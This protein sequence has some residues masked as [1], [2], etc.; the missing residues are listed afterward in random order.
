MLAWTSMSYR[1]S[2]TISLQ[3]WRQ[4]DAPNEA[5]AGGQRWGQRV[6]GRLAPRHGSRVVEE[7]PFRSQRREVPR[8]AIQ[9]AGHDFARRGKSSEH[10]EGGG[11]RRRDGWGSERRAGRSDP[12]VGAASQPRPRPRRGSLLPAL[13]VV[14]ASP[15]EGIASESHVSSGANRAPGCSRIRRDEDRHAGDQNRARSRK[16]VDRHIMHLC[17]LSMANWKRFPNRRD[18]THDRQAGAAELGRPPGTG[19]AVKRRYYSNWMRLEPRLRS[20][21]AVFVS[22][23]DDNPAV[24]RVFCPPNSACTDPQKSDQKRGTSLSPL[25]EGG[26]KGTPTELPDQPESGGGTGARRPAET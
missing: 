26:W 13:R 4:S 15:R 5:I 25:N 3:L 24:A 14:A 2:T 7:A 20:C 19:G 23:F 21:I 17:R 9:F 1:I 8:R 16:H 22:L 10:R 6:R 11:F 12:P 18:R